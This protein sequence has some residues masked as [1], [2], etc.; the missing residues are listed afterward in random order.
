MRKIRGRLKTTTSG[1]ADNAVRWTRL[2]RSSAFQMEMNVGI[3]GSQ[4]D[5]I[6]TK[7]NVGFACDL[8][9]LCAYLIY[10]YPTHCSAPLR[11]LTG[12]VERNTPASEPERVHFSLKSVQSKD[13]LWE[14]PA[15]KDGDKAGLR[16]A[17]APRPTHIARH[18]HSHVAASGN[19]ELRTLADRARHRDC[20]SNL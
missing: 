17:A 16:D 18:R 13:G 5:R 12:W 15:N 6:A 11:W 1:R 7:T 19:G 3:V 9:A 8:V 2:G 14:V 4:L 20:C 10:T